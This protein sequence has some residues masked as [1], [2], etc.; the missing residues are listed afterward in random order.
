VN[1]RCVRPRATDAFLLFGFG[2][3]VGNDGKFAFQNV[4]RSDCSTGLFP[5]NGMT[6]TTPND[7]HC[8][9]QLRGFAG[10]SSDPP[11]APVPD[12]RRLEKGDGRPAATGGAIDKGPAIETTSV[13]NGLR[14]LPPRD[15]RVRVVTESPI[16]DS[17]RN[18]D[19]LPFP[20]GTSAAAAGR[21]YVAVVSEHR[22]EAREAGKVLWSFT[23]EARISATPLLHEDRVF[24][25]SNDGYVYC[26]K[27]ADGALQ[28]KFLAALGHRWMVAYGQLESAWPVPGVVLHNGDLCVSAGRH[29]ELDGGILVFRLDP[30]TGQIRSKKS[31]SRV[32]EWA[33]IDSKALQG[34]QNVVINDALRVV[35][36]KLLLFG[37]EVDTLESPSRVYKKETPLEPYGSRP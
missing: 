30:G 24:V 36:G 3:F 1:N 16:R 32:L 34:H 27:A 6:Y 28:W 19:T 21:E 18:N 9:A 2:I 5:A 31:V 10:F 8:F 25:A 17:W 14:K 4:G 15:I 7:C 37:H 22:L 11:P 12:E 20:L 23:A 29:P 26:L 35:D 13:Q 33:P